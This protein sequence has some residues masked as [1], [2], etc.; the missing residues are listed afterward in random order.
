[1]NL[2][3]VIG[4]ALLFAAMAVFFRRSLKSLETPRFVLEKPP[5]PKD[6]AAAVT[7]IEKWKTEGRIT[8][9]DYE[10]LMY[11]CREDADAAAP[12]KR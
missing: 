2:A 7:R 4:A 9:E 10:R 8:R 1:M 6:L 3:V 5:L 11:L 12:P